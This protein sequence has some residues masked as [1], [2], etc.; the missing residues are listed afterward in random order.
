V[1]PAGESF[2]DKVL[3]LADKH[4]ISYTYIPEGAALQ[5]QQ[6]TGTVELADLTEEKLTYFVKGA[7]VFTMNQV[8]AYILGVLMEPDVT[9]SAENKGSLA[10]QG[11]ITP[12]NGLFPIYRYIHDLNE[13]DFVDYEIVE[14]MPVDVTVY[15]DSANGADTNDGLS[16]A[17]AVKTMNA[18][19]SLL[20]N[21]LTADG[22]GTIVLVSDYT[23]TF[24][25]AKE[26]I[27]SSVSP[28][29]TYCVTNLYS[30]P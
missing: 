5:L 19:Y 3:A 25:T 30:R 13:K 17:T 24:T 21:G 26:R 29:V 1:I 27:S 8:D 15:L 20:D 4:G 10:Q 18:A 9:D 14:V 12:T 22:T 6:Y 11:I 2:T 7:Y 23:H 28:P 16:E